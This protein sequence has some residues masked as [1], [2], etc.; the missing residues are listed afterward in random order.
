MKSKHISGK[1]IDVISE[2]RGWNWPEFY[3]A[4]HEEGAKLDLYPIQNED[5]H[6]EWRG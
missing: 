6:L 3:K 4:L 1:A 5:C 2:S